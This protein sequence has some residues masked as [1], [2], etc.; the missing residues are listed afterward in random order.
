MS[1]KIDTNY[2]VIDIIF[3]TTFV[4]YFSTFLTDIR[5]TDAKPLNDAV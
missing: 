5:L 3:L 2:I 4:E 1:F